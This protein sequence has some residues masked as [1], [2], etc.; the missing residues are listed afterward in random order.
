VR[1]E[2][3]WSI[4]PLRDAHSRELPALFPLGSPVVFPVEMSPLKDTQPVASNPGADTTTLPPVKPTAASTIDGSENLPAHVQKDWTEIQKRGHLGSGIF[5]EQKAPPVTPMA[6]KPDVQDPISG[7]KM[8]ANRKGGTDGL[9]D[10]ASRPIPMA[11]TPFDPSHLTLPELRTACRDRGLNPGGGKDA[12]S[13]RLVDAINAGTCA[14]FLEK[15]N[16][17]AAAGMKRQSP[18]RD[19]ADAGR[20]KIQRTERVT[21]PVTNAP[22]AVSAHFKQHKADVFLTEMMNSPKR[23]DERKVTVSDAKLRDLGVGTSLFAESGT[24]TETFAKAA[25]LAGAAKAKE[26]QGHGDL[27][28]PMDASVSGMNAGPASLLAAR[29]TH[30]ADLHKQSHSI[31]ETEGAFGAIDPHELAKKQS[32]SRVVSAQMKQS[33]FQGSGIFDAA[34]ETKAAASM[35]EKARTKD[36]EEVRNFP[37]HHVPP[38]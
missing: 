37:N 5:D 12:L 18:D 2:K 22:N 17:S 27:F 16:Q 21:N 35:A 11:T 36:S 13:E 26:H 19:A 38:P 15:G 32:G 10:E 28:M 25:T 31:F 4:V 8:F 9:G 24:I 7:M 6:T 29:P 3:Y 30:V 23:L 1:R 14:P 33:L 20:G 34:E